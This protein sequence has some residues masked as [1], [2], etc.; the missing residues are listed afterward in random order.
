MAD[1]YVMKRFNGRCNLSEASA[2]NLMG[3]IFGL[4]EILTEI[5]IGDIFQC[6]IQ[7]RVCGR[8]WVICGHSSISVP[9]VHFYNVGMPEVHKC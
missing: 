2:H 9:I 8:W 5:A 4:I 3:H 1:V 6:D 7:Y